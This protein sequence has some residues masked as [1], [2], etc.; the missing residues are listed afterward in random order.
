MLSTA[1]S[2]AACSCAFEHFSSAVDAVPTSNNVASK[3]SKKDYETLWAP[4][5]EKKVS[6]ALA[7]RLYELDVHDFVP[8]VEMPHTAEKDYQGKF[9]N[10]KRQSHKIKGQ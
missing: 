4:L 7:K 9:L 8:C 5:Y 1:L 6:L 2:T 10:D 3:P